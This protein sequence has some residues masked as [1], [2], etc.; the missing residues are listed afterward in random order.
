[1]DN[2]MCSNHS[3]RFAA[4]QPG[5]QGIAQFAL[6]ADAFI[7]SARVCEAW[8]SGLNTV[9]PRFVPH[10]AF[11]VPGV[12][13]AFPSKGR[14][15]AHG[16]GEVSG[17]NS[18][19]CYHWSAYTDL[20][21]QAVVAK[22]R[23]SVP[24]SLSILETMSTRHPLVFR[25]SVEIL[26]ESGPRRS[27][28]PYVYPLPLHVVPSSLP[29]LGDSLAISRKGIESPSAGKISQSLGLD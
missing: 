20:W 8:R 5:Y 9:G 7:I 24:G 18:D 10:R 13:E 21:D 11:Y 28:T 14:L 29:H 17:T 1:M 26:T 4:P 25:P 15:P 2:R 3:T 12:V 6:G 19:S 16:S 23:R 27:L 22:L